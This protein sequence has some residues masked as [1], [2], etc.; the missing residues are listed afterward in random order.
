MK[1][2]YIQ[3]SSTGFK[4]TKVT[5]SSSTSIKSVNVCTC[6]VN[7]VK[8]TRKGRIIAGPRNIAFWIFFSQNNV[9]FYLTFFKKNE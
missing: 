3:T 9:F 8:S 1:F 6:E 7:K 4:I 5:I 2:S